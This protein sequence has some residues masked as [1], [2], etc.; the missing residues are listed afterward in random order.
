HCGSEHGRW[1]VAL[2]SSAIGLWMARIVRLAPPLLHS[3]FIKRMY[4]DPSRALPG[5]IAE[6][7]RAIAV[8]GTTIAAAKVLKSWVKNFEQLCQ[9]MPDI[10]K[11][12]VQLIWG[13]KDRVVPLET[14][15]ELL[16]ELPS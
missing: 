14:A 11:A 6:Y 10:A 1:Q 16:R 5:T 4:G 12:D 8:P 3:F 7:A 2:F 15:K 9:M 13:D